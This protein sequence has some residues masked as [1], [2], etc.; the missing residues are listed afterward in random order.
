M[1]RSAVQSLNG[2]LLALA[3]FSLGAFPGSATAFPQQSAAAPAT[4]AAPA[5]ALSGTVVEA[6]QAGGYTYLCLENNQQKTWVA[7]PA[8]EVAVGEELGVHPGNQMGPFTSKTLGR[9][10]DRI[11]FSGGPVA[12]SSPVAAPQGAAAAQPEASMPSGHPALPAAAQHEA[13][14]AS[15]ASAAWRP[16]A[17]TVQVAG[18]VKETF[19]AGGYTYLRLEQDGVTSWAAVPPV[20]VKVGDEVGVRPGM[21]MGQFTSKT[22]GRTFDNIVFSSGLTTD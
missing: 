22:L 20:Q 12:A 4:A 8:M 7:I 21:E 3:L 6:M 10:F 19:D 1:K 5:P 9:T 14:A 16:A 11:I 2:S 17:G 18:T 13:T 15:A